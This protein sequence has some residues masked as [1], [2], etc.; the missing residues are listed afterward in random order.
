MGSMSRQVS[1]AVN[2][3]EFQDV[4]LGGLEEIALKQGHKD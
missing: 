2:W 3:S 4:E 1:P